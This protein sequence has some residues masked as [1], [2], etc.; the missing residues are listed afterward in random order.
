MLRASRKAETWTC[1]ERAKEGREDDTHVAT[2]TLTPARVHT[3][4]LHGR[5]LFVGEAL[6]M[7]R[8]EPTSEGAF[9]PSNALRGSSTCILELADKSRC[10]AALTKQWWALCWAAASLAGRF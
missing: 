5:A 9:Y 4:V 2:T 8:G 10:T 6:V 7:K 3:V 1:Q